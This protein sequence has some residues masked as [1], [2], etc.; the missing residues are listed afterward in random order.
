MGSHKHIEILVFLPSLE[1]CKTALGNTREIYFLVKNVLVN[2][3][4]KK[5]QTSNL[6]HNTNKVNLILNN[7]RLILKQVTYAALLN[8]KQWHVKANNNNGT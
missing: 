3:Q 2:F 6:F 7:I 4:K 5:T 8:S 1:F